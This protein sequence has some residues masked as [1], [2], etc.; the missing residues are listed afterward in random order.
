VAVA[1]GQAK[2]P[3]IRAALIGGLVNGLVTS[4]ASAERLLD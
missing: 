4:E 3:A 1:S 2:L